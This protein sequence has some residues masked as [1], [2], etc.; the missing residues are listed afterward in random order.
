MKSAFLGW[1][2]FPGGTEIAQLGYRIFKWLLVF[3]VLLLAVITIYGWL[4]YPDAQTTPL[5]NY[6]ALHDA[7]LTRLKDL[8]QLFLI[9]PVFPLIG[10]VIGYIFGVRQGNG[11]TEK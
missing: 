4:S 7:W 10:A 3:A 6:Q 1:A 9:T 2:R 8:G 11:N 5:E